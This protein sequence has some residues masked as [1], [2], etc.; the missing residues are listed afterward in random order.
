MHFKKDMVFL[1]ECNIYEI[2]AAAHLKFMQTKVR[3]EYVI[4]FPVCIA[5]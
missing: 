1:L 4:Y 3:I 2:D 5:F